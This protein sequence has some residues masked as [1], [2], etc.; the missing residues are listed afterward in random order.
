ML[1]PTRRS[2]ITGL[3][4][5]IAAPAI[6]RVENIMPVRIVQMFEVP[7]T[8]TITRRW[9][10]NSDHAHLLTAREFSK[11]DRLAALLRG[12]ENGKTRLF[13]APNGRFYTGQMVDPGDLS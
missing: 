8:W 1:V 2:F 10:P 4:S 7:G 13:R 12:E 3:V 6:V 11:Y 9:D 5:L